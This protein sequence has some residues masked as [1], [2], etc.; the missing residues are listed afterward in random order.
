MRGPPLDIRRRVADG[1]QD[2]IRHVHRHGTVGMI[3]PGRFARRSQP[4]KLPGVHELGHGLHAVLNEQPEPIFAGEPSPS[5]EGIAETFGYFTRNPQWLRAIGIP[6]EEMDKILRALLAPWFFYLRQRGAFAL[7]GLEVYINPDRDLDR[8]LG[9]IESEVTGARAD[10]TP[11]WTANAWYVA[12]ATWHNY[13][14][15]DMV[16]SQLH[17]GLRQR[18]GE[19]YGSPQAID[20]LRQRY[21]ALG[22]A[23]EWREKLEDISGADLGVT[24]LVG[25]LKR[26]ARSG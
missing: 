17:S 2:G 9:E 18:F 15:A 20:F 14:V 13:L 8:L 25:D 11:R 4:G 7:F 5:S 12:G 19:L 16:A 22:A 26:M 10:S 23:G 24:A 3:D 1:M 21:L 6:D